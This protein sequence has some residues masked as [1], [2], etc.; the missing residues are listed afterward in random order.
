MLSRKGSESSTVALRLVDL[1][2]LPRGNELGKRILNCRRNNLRIIR[3]KQVGIGA[4][5]GRR[6]QR[7]LRTKQSRQ[8]VHS[9]RTTQICQNPTIEP[10]V[11]IQVLQNSNAYGAQF[12]NQYCDLES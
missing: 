4:I 7:L 10:N 9:T 2:A 11:S 1:L 6:A 3:R 8:K 12:A 5:Y